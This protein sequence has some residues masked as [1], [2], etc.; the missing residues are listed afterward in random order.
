MSDVTVN[1]SRESRKRVVADLELSDFHT[2]ESIAD[3]Q[4]RT[5]KQQVEF[6]LSNALKPARNNAIALQTSEKEVK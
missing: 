2:L 1:E 5:I 4:H 6:M 3:D